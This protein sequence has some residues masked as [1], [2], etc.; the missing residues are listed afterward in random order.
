MPDSV[1]T[2]VKN[3]LPKVQKFWEIFFDVISAKIENAIENV[4]A[5]KARRQ[6]ALLLKLA[7]T[8]IK[9]T[10]TTADDVALPF[11]EAV[12]EWLSTVK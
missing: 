2:G 10:P 3:A 1:I 8:I 5:E 12:E 11:I 9:I 7:K 4:D 6:I